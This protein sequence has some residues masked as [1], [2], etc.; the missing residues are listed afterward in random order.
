MGVGDEHEVDVGQVVDVE[1]GVL[2]ALEDLQPLGPDRVDEDAGA[3]G[4]DEEGG[5]A[6]PGDADLALGDLGEDG[7]QFRPVALRE[8]RGDDDLGEEIALVPAGAELH[9]GVALG[10]LLSPLARGDGDLA[11]GLSDFLGEDSLNHTSVGQCP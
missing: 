4:L 7:L 10:A 5:V 8:H 6:D 9:R 2:D 11:A 3:R 1:A